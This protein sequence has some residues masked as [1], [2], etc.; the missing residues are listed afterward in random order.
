MNSC[1]GCY[2]D[3]E[4]EGQL[5]I[6][7]SHSILTPARPVLALTLQFQWGSQE[8]VTVEVTDMAQAVKRKFLS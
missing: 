3:P 4:V 8:R 2:N 1:I 7:P 5:A 6:S